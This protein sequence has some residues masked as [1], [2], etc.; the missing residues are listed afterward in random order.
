[1]VKHVTE[2][3]HEMLEKFTSFLQMAQDSKKQLDPDC[4]E[5]Y[6]NVLTEQLEKLMRR[7]VWM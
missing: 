7:A 3:T 1:M 2:S 5:K 4:N 6:E